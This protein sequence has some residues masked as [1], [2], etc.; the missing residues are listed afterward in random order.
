MAWDHW[1][2][3]QSAQKGAAGTPCW[4]TPSS[5]GLQAAKGRLLWKWPRVA[6]LISVTFETNFYILGNLTFLRKQSKG[7]PWN[8]SMHNKDP[9]CLAM[10]DRL[11]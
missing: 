3:R 2:P 7:T 8:P 5:S 1:C 11:M 4:E 9:T 10:K 6:L